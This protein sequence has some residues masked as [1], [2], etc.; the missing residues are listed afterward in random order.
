MTILKCNANIERI[1]SHFALKITDYYNPVWQ[2]SV[3]SR[4]KKIVAVEMQVFC[5]ENNNSNNNDNATYI[6]YTFEKPDASIHRNS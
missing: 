1:Q 4:Y 2:F 6:N 3:Q 5:L